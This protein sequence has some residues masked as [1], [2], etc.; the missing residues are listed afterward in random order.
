MNTAHR[1]LKDSL[2]HPDQ[3]QQRHIGPRDADIASMISQTGAR[4]SRSSHR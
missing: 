1:H 3:F 2:K 4:L